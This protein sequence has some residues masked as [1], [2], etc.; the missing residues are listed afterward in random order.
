M[1]IKFYQTHEVEPKKVFLNKNHKYYSQM[2]EYLN[3]MGKSLK[4]EDIEDTSYVL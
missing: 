3:A 1:M 4:V 2:K